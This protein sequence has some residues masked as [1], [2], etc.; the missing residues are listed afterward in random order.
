MDPTLGRI[1]YYTKKK[2]HP[3]LAALVTG[4]QREILDRKLADALKGNDPRAVWLLLVPEGD[5][6]IKMPVAE[7]QATW[8][9]INRTQPAHRLGEWIESMMPDIKPDT[10]T[11]HVHG[12]YPDTGNFGACHVAYD[13][14]AEPA[15]NTW[16]WPQ[17][18]AATRPRPDES[19]PFRPSGPV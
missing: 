1:V 14:S 6:R 10:I 5:A 18:A 9:Q 19:Q 3:Q 2:G 16:C 8:E 11:C 13:S 15:D 12:Q 7:F 17:D 4:L